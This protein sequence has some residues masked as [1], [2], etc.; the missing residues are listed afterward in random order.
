MNKDDN[1][2]QTSVRANLHFN[3]TFQRVQVQILSFCHFPTNTYLLL[4]KVSTKGS[5]KNTE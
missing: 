5:G 4:R 2:L 1:N 3:F